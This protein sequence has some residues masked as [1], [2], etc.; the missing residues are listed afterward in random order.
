MV[1]IMGALATANQAINLAQD[2]RGIDKLDAASYRLK[3]ADLT[4]ALSDIKLALTDAKEEYAYKED[5][6]DKLIRTNLKSP[7]R[8]IVRWGKA[9]AGAT[10]L[11]IV[12][13]VPDYAF[14]KLDEQHSEYWVYWIAFLS[15]FL[16][17]LYGNW[18]K[19]IW[20]RK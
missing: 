14:G 12:M 16:G 3:I 9:I 4:N 17:S 19:W 2:L 10:F 5:Q 15:F 7:D 6:I 1:D 11:V 20:Q 18:G 8:L 13:F